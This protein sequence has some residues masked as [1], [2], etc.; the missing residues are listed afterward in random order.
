MAVKTWA[1]SLFCGAAAL[2]AQAAPFQNGS[3]ETYTGAALGTFANLPAGSTDL[4]GWTVVGTGGV[5]AIGTYW[6][7][8]DG[9]VSVDL[10][11]NGGAGSGVEQTFDTVA[12]T[13]YTVTFA[14]SGN[15]VCAA[16]IKDLNVNAT[17]GGV[18]SAYSH[19][20]TGTS[21]PAIPWT[22]ETYVFTATGTSTVLSFTTPNTSACGPALDNVRVVANAAVAVPALSEWS[23]GLLALAIGGLGMR[24]RRRTTL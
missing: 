5:D 24:L 16:P 15:P 21:L 9:A 18:L 17:P 1:L 3:F 13:A 20:S 11:G 19:D 4:T 2:S 6:T 8:E 10:S 23:L 14:L 7:A 22:T 12:G